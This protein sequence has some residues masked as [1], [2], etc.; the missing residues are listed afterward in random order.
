MTIMEVLGF[1]SNSHMVNNLQYEVAQ[2]SPYLVAATRCL[3]HVD[4]NFA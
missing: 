2:I 4:T 1:L 3:H